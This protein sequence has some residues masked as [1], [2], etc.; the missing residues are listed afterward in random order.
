M[1][2]S[3]GLLDDIFPDVH[4]TAQNY[5]GLPA[6]DMTCIRVLQDFIPIRV[7]AGWRSG[8]KRVS[9]V[10]HNCGVLKLSKYT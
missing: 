7:A 5:P 4:V 2:G 9:G 10:F 8:P 6:G 3:G 1:A